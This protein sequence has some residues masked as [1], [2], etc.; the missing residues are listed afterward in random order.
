MAQRRNAPTMHKTLT[1][2]SSDAISQR[3]TAET[4]ALSR[5]ALAAHQ[6]AGN[7]DGIRHAQFEVGFYLLWSG[8]PMG[9]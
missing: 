3:A 2:W 7:P 5:A 6:E 1:G 9:A 4:V 8:D